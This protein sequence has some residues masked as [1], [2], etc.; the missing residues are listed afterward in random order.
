[1]STYTQTSD[2]LRINVPTPIV[3]NG[4]EHPL[5]NSWP[6]SGHL[7]CIHPPFARSYLILQLGQ[8]T[9]KAVFM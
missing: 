2:R 4:C 8:S 9:M 7:K 3:V 5:Q 6:H 1:M